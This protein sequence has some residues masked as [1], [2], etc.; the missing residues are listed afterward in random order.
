MSYKDELCILKQTQCYKIT[1]TLAS[2]KKK[3]NQT[4]Q[5]ATH[6]CHKSTLQAISHG[7]ERS[8]L[9]IAITKLIPLACS[10]CIAISLPKL[11]ILQASYYILIRFPCS[12][13]HRRQLCKSRASSSSFHYYI[14]SNFSH[15][16][17]SLRQNRPLVKLITLM[18]Q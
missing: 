3:Q 2:L 10:A 11:Q 15:T 6:V 5:H 12:Q 9:P 1:Y 13:S 14:F 18:K 4:Q 8:Y 7:R 17:N 16:Y